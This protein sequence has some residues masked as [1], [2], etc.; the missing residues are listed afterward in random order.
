M[1][2]TVNSKVRR[3]KNPAAKPTIEV[4][5]EAATTNFLEGVTQE[6][7]EAEARLWTE[8]FNATK[9]E[10]LARLEKLFDEDIAEGTLPLD[11]TGK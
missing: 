4:Q 6:E 1:T 8:K 7:L 9:P 10:Q 2:Q 11:F 5:K 3:R